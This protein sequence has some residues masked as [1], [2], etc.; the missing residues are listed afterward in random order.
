MLDKHY[1]PGDVEGRIYQQW[2][3]AGAFACGTRP[4]ART[5]T[6]VIPPPNVTGSLHMGHAL[7]NTLQD[8][9]IRYQR[10]KGLDVLWQPGTDHAGI[11][12]QMVVERQM[13]AEGLTRHDLGRDKFIERVWK[14]KLESGGTITG[15]LRRLGASCDWGRERFTMDD[16]LSKAVQKV[17]VELHKAGLI[18]RDKRLVNWD[19]LLHTAI[20]DLEVE[21]RDQNGKMW[22]FKYPIEGEDGQFVTV[23]TTRPETMLGDTGV[24]VHPDDER[25]K[26]LVGKRVMLPIANRSIPIVADE[27][28]DPE[29]G[30]GAVKMTPAHDFNDFEVGRRHGLMLINVLDRN[31]CIISD[32]P[33]NKAMP[34]TAP[35]SEGGS[36][37][38]MTTD[39]LASDVGIPQHL[40]GLD[41]FEARDVV[42][43]EMENLGLLEKVEDNPMTVP[44]GDRSGVVIE[45]WLLDQWFVDAAT[46]A[47][48]A[49]KAVEDGRTTFHPKNYENIYFDWMRNI[50]PWCV[51]RQIWWGHQI[52]AWYGPDG[53]PFVEHTEAEAQTAADAH[54]AMAVDIARD[55]DVLDTWFSSALWPFSTL[56][57]PEDT[58]EVGRYYPTDVLVTGFDIIFFWV[59]RMMMMGLHFMDEVP[60]KDVYI[61]ALV[62]D[63]KGQKMSKSK[64]NVM[65]PLELIDQFGADAVRFTMTAQAVQGRDVKLSISRIE[66]YRNFVTKIW[67]AARYAEMNDCKPDATFSPGDCKLTV[68]RWVV[69][70]TAEAQAAIAKAIESYRFNEAA[71]AGYHFTWG[72]FCDWYVEFTKPILTGS[73]EAA[74]LETRATMAWAFDEILKML[75]PVMPFVTEEL[76]ASITKRDGALM[77]AEWSALDGL[78]AADAATE[79]DWVVRLVSSVRAVRSEMNVPPKAEL[80]LRLKDASTETM[81]RLETNRDLIHRLARLADSAAL[82]GA[83]EKGAVQLVLDEATVILPL[84]GAIDVVAEQARLDK[85][86]KKL[87][88]EINKYEKKLSNQGFLAKAPPEVVTEQTE[89]LEGLKA[90]RQKLAEAVKR[91][92][93]L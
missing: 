91:L 15:Q 67:N 35:M 25:Y 87:D 10:M 26:A 92:A 78:E 81:A 83:V 36:K 39:M 44:Y 46:L 31:G 63:E 69:A 56:G 88:P 47:A 85:E 3:D 49:I 28:A 68:N 13:E 4:D 50:Q 34:Y 21:N 42:V 18:Y 60:F 79:M 55:P 38:A 27:Y 33:E 45:P 9:L 19:P 53:T 16:G 32:S 64:G 43:K 57:W 86:I 24:A 73:D 52:P 93:E 65:D 40:H 6:I 76:W 59:A 41:R 22:Y 2:E 58:P 14:W 29:K 84:A 5:Y 74:K 72:T 77:L 12:T 20:S 17:F 54:Y 70:K 80:S 82:D 51:S 61:H 37:V 11:A 30:T 7:N 71:E 90:E 62:R 75:H 23:G 1:Q 66:G 48:P 89:R 8:I